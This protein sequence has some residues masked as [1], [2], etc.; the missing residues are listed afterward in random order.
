MEPPFHTHDLEFFSVHQKTNLTMLLILGH[1][2]IIT[3]QESKD[4]IID[5]STKFTK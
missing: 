3:I 1:F 2:Y 4:Q 5:H